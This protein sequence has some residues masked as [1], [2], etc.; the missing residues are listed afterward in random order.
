MSKNL[1]PG[2]TLADFKLHDHA[3][4]MRSLSELQ[5]DDAMIL[6]LGRA[7]TIPVSASTSVRW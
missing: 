5:G 7:S 4:T 6:M 3:G 1:V 2:S